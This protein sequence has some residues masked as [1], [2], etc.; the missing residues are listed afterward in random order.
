MER[1]G[2]GC[3]CV[4]HKHVC[5]NMYIVGCV[6]SPVIYVRFCSVL[7]FC[8]IY[9][10]I[11]LCVCLFIGTAFFCLFVFLFSL[12]VTYSLETRSVTEPET[13]CFV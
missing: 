6:E 5:T 9:L 7:F 3:V 12:S 8:F 4:W 13:S 11:Y 2:G 10:F 1:E